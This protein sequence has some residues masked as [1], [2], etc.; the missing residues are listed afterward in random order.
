MSRKVSTALSKNTA[1]KE[2]LF[3]VPTKQTAYWELLFVANTGANNK[4]ATI[5]WYDKSKNLETA[6]INKSF[7][8][9]E[10]LE[11][12]G[13]GK[14]VAMDEGDEIRVAIQDNL[15]TFAFIVSL[16]L[17][18]KATTQYQDL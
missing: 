12:G 5:Y 9:G 1:A 11:W 17:D 15:T 2:T 16:N 8:A 14:Y 4:T 6:I 3:T 10:S 13:D 18:K 7:S